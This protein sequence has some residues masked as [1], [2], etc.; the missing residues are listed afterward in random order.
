MTPEVIDALVGAG[1]TAEMIAAALKAE[2]AVEDRQAAERQTMK[3]RK[4]ETGRGTRLPEDWSPSAAEVAFAL[5]RG[6]PQSRVDTEA[7]K[8]LNYWRAKS[9][10]G[11]T[12]RDWCAT[13]RNWI[14]TAMER[15]SGPASYRGVSPRINPPSGRAPTGSDAILAGMGRL[16]N[17]IDQRR[18][19]AAPERRELSKSTDPSF[20]FDVEPSRAR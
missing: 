4:K 16:A 10:V 15:G 5:D 20:A 14:I 7:E 8:F 1:A 6:M 17:K 19:P 11:A 2:K 12:K 9:G 18:M 3:R 13:W